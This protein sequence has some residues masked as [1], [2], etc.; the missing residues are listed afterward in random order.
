MQHD[1]NASGPTPD[2]DVGTDGVSRR[3]VLKTF[4]AGALAVGA[5]RV[6]RPEIAVRRTVGHVARGQAAGGNV[7]KIGYVTPET[8]ALADFSQSDVFVLDKVRSSAPFAK[9][10]KIGGRKYRLEITVVDSQSSPNRAAQVAQ[11]LV[12]QNKVDIVVTSSAPETTNP[13]ASTCEQLHVPNLATVVPWEAWYGGL[14]GNPVSP[15][16]S[17]PYS[18]M[19]FF[20]LKEFGGTF[21]PMW[22][23][24]E[25]KTHAAKIYAAMFPNDADGNAFRAAW[26]QY[27]AAVGYKEVDG[28]AY[29]DGTTNYSSMIEKFKS[30]GCE[31]YVNA[32]LPPDF[33]TFWKQAVQQGFKPKLATV[34]KVLLFPSD[35]VALGSLVNN[36]ATDAWW[37]PFAPYK[38]SLTGETAKQFALDYENKTGREWV[39]S[40]GSA[41]SLFE[42]VVAALNKVSDPHHKAEVAH[43]LH[44]L[45]YRGISGPINF[46]NG[47]APGV[48]I[49]KPVGIQWK[50]G[51]KQNGRKFP[52]E[53]FVVDNSLNKAVPIN[54]DLEPTNP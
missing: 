33:N 25:A 21:L 6:V 8:G 7:V 47:P 16:K 41:Y 15:T 17:Y 5:G 13:V 31:F 10:M 39:Q 9:G 11:Q 18:S 24:I 51:K 30:S 52:W 32:P 4:G 44:N 43:A 50:Q 19:F 40:M 38:S 48:G 1:E 45:S 37:T 3:T 23:R 27:P 12:L 22:Q 46:S 34:A 54:G 29:T 26:P 28:G 20:G 35:V 2:G 53:P 14:G 49:V 42:V 36:I